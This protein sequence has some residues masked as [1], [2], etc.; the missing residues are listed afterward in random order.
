[1]LG[2][3]LSFKTNR[4]RSFYNFFEAFV[5]VII[6]I[7]KNINIEKD[8]L[9]DNQ[10]IIIIAEYFSNV[11]ASCKIS[12]SKFI[13]DNMNTPPAYLNIERG[14]NPYSTPIFMG[15]KKLKTKAI[16]NK[17]RQPLGFSPNSME[18]P[19]QFHD[20]PPLPLINNHISV[21]SI[22]RCENFSQKKERK[23]M[24]KYM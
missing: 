16:F 3:S 5:Y 24:I 19:N 18:I 11:P 8:D 13:K 23:E 2:C 10:I 6:Q 14:K 17:R 22:I 4:A 15:K 21:R 12:K 20:T 1:M 9:Q 7:L